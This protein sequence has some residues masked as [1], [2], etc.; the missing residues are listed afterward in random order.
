MPVVLLLIFHT[1]H[2]NG[3]PISNSG[4]LEEIMIVDK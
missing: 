2:V 1:G 3:A 4:C